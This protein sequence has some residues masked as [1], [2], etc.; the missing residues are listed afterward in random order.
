MLVVEH[1]TGPLA[2][3]RTQIESG[4]ERVMV[5]RKLDCQ[6]VYPPETTL[7][8]RNHFALVRKPSG[9]WTVD[10]FGD[11]YVA[12][13][14]LTA[15]QN[16]RVVDG[17][18]IEL[19]RPGGP[20]F[21]TV[22]KDET[23]TDN[24][25]VTQA[26]WHDTSARVLAKRAR[27]FAGV[28]AIVALVA[29]GFGAYQYVNPTTAKLGDELA[30]LRTE[31]AAA[32]EHSI[33]GA[34]RDHL[35]RSVFL[36]MKK[37]RS[38]GGLNGIG[39]AWPVGPHQLGTNAHVAAEADNLRPDQVMVV[40][41]PGAEGKTYEIVK[42]TSHP[43]YA[44]LAKFRD[45]EKLAIK[46]AEGQS[47]D[48]AFN[49]NGYDVALLQVKEDIPKE[50][51]FVLASPQELQAMRAGDAVASAGY[52]AE[53]ISGANAGLIHASPELH[54]GTV[55][56]LTDFFFLPTDEAHRLLVHHDLPSAGGASG[57][58]IVNPAGHVVAL[59]SAGNMFS[60]QDT[61]G[62]ENRVPDAA[63]INYGQRVDMLKELMD[64]AADKE[65]QADQSYWTRQIAFFKRDADLQIEAIVDKAKP[66]PDSAAASISSK[67][68]KLGEADRKP[69]ASGG[70]QRQVAVPMPVVPG[71]AYVFVAIGKNK[72]D[73]ELYLL[74]GNRL[75]D[76]STD[77]GWHPYIRYRANTESEV[78]LWVVNPNDRDVDFT[79]RAYRFD[80]KAPSG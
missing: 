31:Q 2:G 16:Q 12:I 32:A 40:Q 6:V 54:V 8:S 48:V 58:P 4:V 9:D 18:R 66:A 25:E 14:G 35:S 44:A 69:K 79:L 62:R 57:S 11:P 28:G 47:H 36:V 74:V 64:G 71:A 1:L 65:L 21:R 50:Q 30:K 73:L 17:S 68:M 39:T 20:S 51:Q 10:L 42:H 63:L 76:R 33:G 13:D 72:T 59:L 41:A 3:T 77:A 46:G 34:V 75:V 61:K 78:T 55:T 38:T 53:N 52:P 22:I 67:S 49:I 26:Q 45:A 5:G 56:G 43:G 70:N 80:T 29:A 23:A 19:G 15:D 24:Y 60:I 27:M 7:V 37:N